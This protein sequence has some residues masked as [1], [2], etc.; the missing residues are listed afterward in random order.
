MKQALK[1]IYKHLPLKKQFFEAV[2]IFAAPGE[3]TY[4]HLH[5]TGDFT[6][7][8]DKSHQF[9]IR[10]YGYEVENSLFWAGVSGGWEK[11]SLSLWIE[12]VKDAKVIFDIGAN[13]GVYSLIAKAINREAKVYAFE[14]VKRVFEK[15]EHNAAINDFDIICSDNAASNEDGTATIY[16]TPTEHTYSVTV[17][18]NLNE[19][20]TKVIPTQIETIRLDTFI[21]QTGLKKLD[22]IKLDV[23]TF[24]GEVLEGLGKYLRAFKPTLLIEIL[25]DEVGQKVAN[26]V[27]DLDYLYFNIDDVNHS[28]RQ[29]E[30]LTKSDYFNYLICS[31]ETAERINI[32]LFKDV[33]NNS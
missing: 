1:K 30:K 17:N 4:K 31:P 3:N 32:T 13:T 25:N 18:K 27:G 7:K 8:I 28:I 24:E 2:K 23:E 26:L 5:F 12:L 11:V 20:D 6:V 19:K 21:E 14:P 10:H 33:Q 9:R 29:T 15:L 16:D 22:L